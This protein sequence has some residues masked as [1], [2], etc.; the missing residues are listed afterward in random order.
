MALKLP[1]AEDLSAP[2]SGRSGR[3]IA[4]YDTS[5]IGRGVAQ[6]GAGMQSM[7][8][9]LKI[10]ETQA[11][12]NV[13]KAEL[14]STES[15]YLQFKSQQAQELTAAGDKAEPGA[16]GFKEQFQGSYKDAAKAFMS[17][18]PAAL[19]PVYDQKLFNTE[20]N[21][22]NGEGGAAD[23]E[24][25][26]RK[27]YYKT[28]VDEGLTAIE[29]RLYSDPSKFDDAVFEGNNYIDSIPDDDVNPIEKDALRRGWKAKAQMAALNGMKPAD[30]LR[31][32]GE[33]P[34]QDDIINAMKG[35]ESN[36]DPSA[37]SNK[38][39]IGEMQVMPDTAV[40]IA[41]DLQDP[42]F[43]KTPEAQEEYL[44]DPAV[45]EKYG[46]Y[47]FNKMLARYD[48]DT[49]A[50]L[51]AYN[52]GADR[53]D[54]WLASGRNDA[55]IPQES[56]DY[57]K[58]VL[59]R[60]KPG[61]DGAAQST[62]RGLVVPGNIDL[63]SRPVVKNADGSISTVRS[64]SYENDAGQEVLIPTVSD[65]GKVMSNEEAIKYWGEK[66]Q[67]LGK[68]DNADDATA[69]AQDLH[70]AQARQYGGK[71]QPVIIGNQAGRVGSADVAGVNSVVMNRFKQ[72]QNAF[73]AS[74]PIVSGYRD[75][76]RNARAGGARKSEHMHGNALDLD[77]SKLSTDERVRLIQTASSMGF[78]GIGVYANSLH[79]DIGSRRAWGASHHSDS[80]P[81]WAREVIAAHLAGK[82]VPLGQRGGAGYKVDPRFAD[83]DYVTRDTVAK[84]ALKDIQTEATAARVRQQAEYKAYDDAMGLNI[85]TGKIVSEDQI[86]SDPVLDDG[87]ITKQLKAFRSK[88]K[89]DGGVGA[90]V[91]AILAGSPAASVNSFDGDQKSTANKA[92][93]QMMKVTPQEQQ[94]VVTQGF[95]KATGYIPDT[96]QA[97]V[98]QGA[99]S[100]DPAIFAAA[101]SQADALQTVAPVSFGAVEGAA[102]IR[103]K[104][105]SFRH[106]VN[107]RGMSGEEA[108]QRILSQD[109]PA[110]KVNREVLKPKLE[111]FTKTLSVAD[112]TNEFDPGLFSS[113][114]AAGVI[115][116]Q[117]SAL[118]AEYK[119]I[120]EEKFYATGGDEGAAKAQALAEM[121][122][123]W[124]V[125][126][127][128]G[129]PNLMRLPP[130]L[131]YPPID[132]KYDYLR[133]DA[134]KTAQ[135]YV[136]GL[137][138]GRKVDNIAILPSATTRADIEMKRPPRYR[139]FY[140]YAEGGQ[141]K[142][143]EVFSGSWGIDP[144]SLSTGVAKS[145]EDAKKRFL[146]RHS[147]DDAANDIDRAA[148]AK[149][150]AIN[151]DTNT[152]DFIKALGS[153]A[154]IGAGRVRSD[155]L[156]S[157]GEQQDQPP[158]EPPPG[159]K[160]YD[161]SQRSGFGVGSGG[162]F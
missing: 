68:F 150:K 15:R 24:R 142:F 139:L 118:M 45:S 54:K 93:D 115:S 10:R 103:D 144:Q 152:Q 13:D 92:Y 27:A 101:M 58:K 3:P 126:N 34:G 39:A 128:S 136:A 23:F 147:I 158:A 77:V 159:T 134:M 79:L 88:Q 124:N 98:R 119:E 155:M 94:P 123:R 130:E 82:S 145:S 84:S 44:K 36:R 57:Y 38:G 80:V 42:N 154:T 63:N 72:V 2:V 35:V 104:L 69:Y 50:A 157:Q 100:K 117:S 140:T 70:N 111:A 135:E 127:I 160:T 90:L 132:G 46:T 73:G 81:N 107:D 151:E 83:M 91:S 33:A 138:D 4:T 11:K 112:V 37:V 120:A 16:F 143:D 43:P 53:A 61:A 17:T 113:A 110:Q 108:S 60:T 49:E 116:L 78:T 65:E 55:V 6:L 96:L 156:R 71:D 67:F 76:E 106:F 1:G 97:Q 41:A 21:L 66:G 95:V 133:T 59:A 32:L 7:A 48:G 12:E 153:E 19:K 125:S 75:P 137:H 87:D 121:K 141:T 148:V 22:V 62:P 162:K 28:N 109:D 161:G 29:S 18:V 99:A 85:E 51:I 5:A 122:T 56:A 105:A 52:G 47:Y 20:E 149:A 131:H 14:F 64:M 30:R 31:A 9:N 129:S 86:L 114:P 89:E 146:T 8:S 26:Q 102:D 40:E 25:K 74:V